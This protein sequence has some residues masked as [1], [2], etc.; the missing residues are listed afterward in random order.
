MNQLSASLYADN[1]VTAR[2]QRERRRTR[3]SQRRPKFSA[4]IFS[5]SHVIQG[6]WNIKVISITVKTEVQKSSELWSAGKKNGKV[7]ET[8]SS[9][10]FLKYL[11]F[12]Q[13]LESEPLRL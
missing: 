10:F 7:D 11:L 12:Q 2:I 1:L 8:S 4:R 3:F 6:I 13:L 5:P 9:S